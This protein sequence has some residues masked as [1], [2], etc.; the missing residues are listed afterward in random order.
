MAL[1]GF[2]YDPLP[3]D[4]DNVS[5]SACQVSL[6]GWEVGDDPLKEHAARRPR[7]AL[8]KKVREA[9]EREA[10]M[11]PE[12]IDTSSPMEVDSREDKENLIV[13]SLTPA[14]K[15]PVVLDVPRLPLL[16]KLDWSQIQDAEQDLTVLEFIKLRQET[17]KTRLEDE[18]RRMLSLFQEAANRTLMKE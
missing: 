16:T 1:A 5:C 2:H 4:I 9:Y 8:V 10:A 17:A 14:P 18:C 15:S 6:Q 11:I 3:E 7:C 12:A 13:A